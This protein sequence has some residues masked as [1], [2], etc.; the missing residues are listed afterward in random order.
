M[1]GGRIPNPGQAQARGSRSLRRL[2]AK[3]PPPRRNADVAAGAVADIAVRRKPE[4]TRR[5]KPQSRQ[6]RP[7]RHRVAPASRGR[8][9]RS[10]IRGNRLRRGNRSRLWPRLVPAFL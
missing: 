9:K 1:P 4:L 3:T 5:D 10:R 6:I 2:K 7:R 8:R